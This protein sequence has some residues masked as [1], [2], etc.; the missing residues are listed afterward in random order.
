MEPKD[1]QAGHK[2]SII[3]DKLDFNSEIRVVRDDYILIDLIVANEKIVNFPDKIKTS[4]VYF[5]DEDKL[6]SWSNIQIVPVK[7]KDG[8]KYHKISMPIEEGKKYNRRRHY[9]LYVG[10]EMRVD[11]KNGSEKLSIMPIIKDISAS[12]FCFIYDEELEIG[13]RVTLFFQSENN[14]PVDYNGKVVRIQYNENLHSNMYGCVI[15]DP[16]GTLGKII[17]AIQ[18][19]KLNER[20]K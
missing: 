9:R 15:N 8:Q 17:N 10:E 13:Q 12:G 6:Y 19:K 14:K 16:G 20:K 5:D 7:F 2:I 18:Q 3:V 4:M 11:I 1:I